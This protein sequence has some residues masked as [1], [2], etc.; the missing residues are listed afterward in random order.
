MKQPELGKK[1]SEL[2]K[3]KGLTQE[4]LVDKCNINVRTI[5]RIEAG[6]V[7]P[8]RYTINAILEALDYNFES[9]ELIESTKHRQL[10]LKLAWIFGIVFFIIG[11]FEFAAD[12]NRFYTNEILFSKPVYIVIKLTVLISYL[13]FIYGFVIISDLFKNSILKITSYIL[14]FMLILAIGYDISSLFYKLISP[15][16]IL[17]LEAISFGFIQIIFGISLIKLQKSIGNISLVAGITEIIT[18][19]LLVTV[20]FAIAGLIVYIPAIIFEVIILY[21]AFELTKKSI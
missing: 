7:T 16:I 21:K 12:Y 10:F 15:E 19:I 5:Q 2:R 14:G 17:P 6:D 4:E 1:I 18:G 9:I 11:F 13:I 3:S 8:R 20:I